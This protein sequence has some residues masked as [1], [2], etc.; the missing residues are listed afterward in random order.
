MAG[1]ARV[2]TRSNRGQWETSV[3]G[4]SDLS[5]SFSSRA[6]AIEYGATTASALGAVH[7]IEPAEPTG[8]ITDEGTDVSLPPTTDEHGAPVDN[9]SG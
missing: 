1:T 2:V 6:E 8:V 3:E 7:R 5:R 4:R 9:P